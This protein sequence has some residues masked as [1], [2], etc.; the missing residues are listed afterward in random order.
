M[1]KNLETGEVLCVYFPLLRKTLLIDTRY[2]VEDQPLVKL[3]PMV[4]SVEERFRSLRRLRPRFPRP[5]SIVVIPWPKYVDSLVR[6]GLWDVLIRRF[7]SLGQLEAVRTC[8]EVIRE[9]RALERQELYS[10]I[11]GSEQYHSLWES[12]K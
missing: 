4:N 12:G 8:Q 6:L 1:A 7:A 5:E 2:D 3:V 11:K 9:L 10:A